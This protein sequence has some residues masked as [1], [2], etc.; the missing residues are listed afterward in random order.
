MNVTGVTNVTIVTIV[1]QS[2]PDTGFLAPYMAKFAEKNSCSR[3]VVRFGYE[4]RYS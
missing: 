4:I 2:C 1:A 3:W